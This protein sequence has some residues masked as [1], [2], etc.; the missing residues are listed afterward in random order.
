MTYEKIWASSILVNAKSVLS[1]IL[2]FNEITSSCREV[3]T[4][5]N[6]L[7][8]KLNDGKKVLIYYT[9]YVYTIKCMAISSAVVFLMKRENYQNLQKITTKWAYRF[10]SNKYTVATGQNRPYS[11]NKHRLAPKTQ[12]KATH[13]KISN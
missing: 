3:R 8:Q 13:T 1:Y 12:I 10:Q 7:K 4:N 11:S 2:I 6:A 5:F 9:V